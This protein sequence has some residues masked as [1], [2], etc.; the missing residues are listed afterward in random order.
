MLTARQFSHASQCF[1]DARG[2]RLTAWREM[3]E[4]QLNHITTRTLM[5]LGYS[6]RKPPW[7]HSC[8]LRNGTRCCSFCRLTKTEQQKSEKTLPGRTSL[9][10]CFDIRT[11]DS[12]FSMCFEINLP[13]NL[14]ILT[15]SSNRTVDLDLYVVF[16]CWI[17]IL[18][19]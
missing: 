6:N 19:E 5:Q 1:I 14:V 8:L 9:S 15:F 11:V 17:W 13:N 3:R 2:W 18:T 10:F 7:C 16:Y 4:R 12:K